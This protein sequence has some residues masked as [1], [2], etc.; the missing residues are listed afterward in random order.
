MGA[1]YTN[2]PGCRHTL[3]SYMQHSSERGEHAFTRHTDGRRHAGTNTPGMLETQKEA[4]QPLTAV[5]SPC[6]KVLYVFN[7]RQKYF[8]IKVT[9]HRIS[10]DYKLGFIKC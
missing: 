9:N 8:T 5:P 6:L 3:P 2:V 1:L 10:K 7:Q 4:A